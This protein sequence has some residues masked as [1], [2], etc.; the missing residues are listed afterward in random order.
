LLECGEP[1]TTGEIL[2]ALTPVERADWHHRQVSMANALAGLVRRGLIRR[3]GGVNGTRR[4]IPVR[5]A[6]IGPQTP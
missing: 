6:V 5:V 4:R 3:E 2:D 1:M